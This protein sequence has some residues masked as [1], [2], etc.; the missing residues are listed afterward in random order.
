[1]KGGKGTGRDQDYA[2][3]MNFLDEIDQKFNQEEIEEKDLEGIK[4]FLK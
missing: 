4:E 1:M 3:M 2:E